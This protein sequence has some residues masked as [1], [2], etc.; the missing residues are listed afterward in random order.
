MP[1]FKNH[2]VLEIT[3][4][5]T[6]FLKLDAGLVRGEPP[7]FE[8]AEPRVGKI[9]QPQSQVGKQGKQLGQGPQEQ[10]RDQRITQLQERSDM[11]GSSAP[12]R[13][14]NP[15]NIVWI[16]GAGRSGSTWLANMMA[17]MPRTLFWNEPMIGRLFGEF[18]ESAEPGR[19]NSQAYALAKPAKKGWMPLIREFVLGSVSFRFPDVGVH[20]SYL[21]VKEPNSSVGA[22][23]ISEALPESGIIFLIRDPRDVVAS[24]VDG[25]RTGSWLYERK[26]GRRGEASVADANPDKFVERRSKMYLN[27]ITKAKEAYEAHKGPKV[28]VRYEELRADT[29]A[30]MKRIYSKLGIEVSEEELE[31]AVE[32]HAWENIPEEEKGEGKKFRKAT[33]GGWREDLTPEQARMVEEITAPLLKEFYPEDRSHGA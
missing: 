27:H 5:I 30:T 32:K 33:P 3:R 6:A 24:V 16:F 18:Y 20:Q 14:V 12:A 10:E 21:V 9:E 8:F 1:V 26:R 31:R 25:A 15:T 7:T 23:L 13:S 28:L 29:L 17:E 22:P 11:D 19:H 2:M 4:G